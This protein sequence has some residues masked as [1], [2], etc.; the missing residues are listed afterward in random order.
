M[1]PMHAHTRFTLNAN[2]ET[3]MKTTFCILLAVLAACSAVAVD[4]QAPARLAAFVVSEQR[5]ESGRFIDTPD[6]PRLGYIKQTPDIIFAEL[7]AVAHDKSYTIVNDKGEPV[8]LNTIITIISDE[9]E[10][11]GLN[12]RDNVVSITLRPEDAR[13][14]EGLTKE[15]IGNKILLMLDETPLTAPVV[16]QPIHGPNVQIIVGNKQDLQKIEDGLRRLVKKP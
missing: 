13:K 15:N 8:G 4:K 7:E 1:S 11:V 3:R 9:G 6:F 10:P 14:F 12:R 2:L 5:I 16:V